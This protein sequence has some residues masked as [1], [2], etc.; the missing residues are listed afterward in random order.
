M[1]TALWIVQVLSGLAFLIFGA[2][3]ATQAKEKLAERMTWV[4]DFDANVIK[5]IGV[6]EILA[7]IGLIL[8]ML[9]NIAPL[10][11]PL[12][13]IG[14]VLTMIGAAFT[15]FR[16]NNM[17]QV[18]LAVVLLLMSAFVAYGRIGLLID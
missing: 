5:G 14:L 1:D 9:L 10:F 7:A 6:L 11:T 2:I 15:Q 12:A 3:K 16:H 4:N 17:P 13:A 8:P 18:A